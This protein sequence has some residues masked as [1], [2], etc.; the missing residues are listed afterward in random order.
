MIKA[1]MF[2]SGVNALTA[3]G[4]AFSTSTTPTFRPPDVSH[5]SS[6]PPHLLVFVDPEAG[7][8]GTLPL[9]ISDAL[10]GSRSRVDS[11]FCPC[12]G[13]FLDHL[14]EVVESGFDA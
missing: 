9:R 8:A 10:H 2:K 6:R 5:S 3:R 4:A 13:I 12:L 7:Q 11:A 1:S 14:A